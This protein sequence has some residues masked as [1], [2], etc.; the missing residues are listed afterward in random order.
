MTQGIR[1]FTN[2][3]FA[4]TLPKLQS[5]ELKPSEFRREVMDLAVVAFGIMIANAWHHSC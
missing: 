1:E 4:S 3:N 2:A 5:G